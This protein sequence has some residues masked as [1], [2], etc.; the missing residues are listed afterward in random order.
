VGDFSAVLLLLTDRS[1][2]IAAMVQAERAREVL[3]VCRGT[4]REELILGYLSFDADVRKG[5]RVVT[6]GLGSIFWLKGLPIGQV[7]S[8][9][10]QEHIASLEARV[11]PFVDFRRLEEM[12]LLIPPQEVQAIREERHE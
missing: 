4:G 2:H 6:S 8:V 12:L 1:A 7:I 11:R 5:D 3:G 10:R 9:R